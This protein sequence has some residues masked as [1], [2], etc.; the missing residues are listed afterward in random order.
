MGVFFWGLGKSPSL[1]ENWEIGHGVLG[2][3]GV[4]ACGVSSKYRTTAV[5]GAGMGGRR[6]TGGAMEVFWGWCKWW[7]HG[8]L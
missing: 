1:I 7:L 8:L 2:E 3:M 6:P 5:I 4:E